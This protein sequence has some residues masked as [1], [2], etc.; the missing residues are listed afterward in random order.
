MVLAFIVSF[1]RYFYGMHTLS[2][3]YVGILLGLIFGKLY[4][5]SSHSNNWLLV[6]W[7]LKLSFLSEHIKVNELNY[8]FSNSISRA[9]KTMSECHE[10]RRKSKK[11]GTDN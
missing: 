2:Q 3:V 5:Y 11:T 1:S 6:V 4:H 9:S 7:L 10:A 8:Y